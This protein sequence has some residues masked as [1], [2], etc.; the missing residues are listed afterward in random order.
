VASLCDDQQQQ[1]QQM[2]SEMSPSLRN[3]A[4]WYP[5]VPYQSIRLLGMS[6]RI[7]QAG[8]ALELPI[9]YIIFGGLNGEY[10]DKISGITVRAQDDGDGL[11]DINVDFVGFK[12]ATHFGSNSVQPSIEWPFDIDGPRGER[13]TG[14]DTFESFSFQYLNGFRVSLQSRPCHHL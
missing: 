9:C 10:L 3:T 5:R 6:G 7:L 4:L 11:L 1:Q 2:S 12:R 13:I 8:R 14:I